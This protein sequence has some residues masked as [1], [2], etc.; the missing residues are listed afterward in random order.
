MEASSPN[1]TSRGL[2]MVLLRR[3]VRPR[4]RVAVVD[5]AGAAAVHVSMA[6]RQ[7]LLLRLLGMLGRK[8]APETFTGLLG[9]AGRL[10][11]SSRGRSL[12]S[13][14][15]GFWG[16]HLLLLHLHL[17]LLVLMQ[18]GHNASCSQKDR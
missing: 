1:N 11:E 6:G 16:V 14:A 18:K 7:R 12:P 13:R 8:L 2:V 9:Q 3:V 5:R 4:Q 10:G 15:R 17:C